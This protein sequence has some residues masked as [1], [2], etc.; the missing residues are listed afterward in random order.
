MA[1]VKQQQKLKQLYEKSMAE[2]G[3][4]L[5]KKRWEQSL[6][7]NYVEKME[8][9]EDGQYGVRFEQE[10]NADSTDRLTSVSEWNIGEAMY[11]ICGPNWRNMLESNKERLGGQ[12]FE[13]FGSDIMPG[14]MSYVTAGLDVVGGL[15]NARALEKNESPEWIYDRVVNVQEAT[16]EGGFHIGARLD[17]SSIDQTGTDL[18]DGQSPPTIKTIG[19]RVHRNRTLR[20]RRRTKLNYWTLKWDLT[21]QAMDAVDETAI[22]VLQERERKCA[23]G[24]LGVSTGTTLG[25]GTSQGIQG[26]ALAMTQDGLNFFPWQNGTYG[27]NANAT[28][29]AQENGVAVANF[30]NCADSNGIGLTNYQCIAQ[31]LQ[32]LHGNRDPFTKLPLRLD[33]NRMQFIC[34]PAVAATQLKTL[35]QQQALWQ[36]AW[37]SATPSSISTATVSDYNLIKE[38][39]LDIIESQFWLN[40]AVDAGLY[41][42]SSTGAATHQTLT[43]NSGDTQNTPGSIMSA[44]WMGHFKRACIY[45]QAQPYQAVQV[46]LDSIAIGEETVLIQDHCERGQLF[47]HQP[48]FGWRA[49]A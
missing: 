29:P 22:L 7:I 11:S 44:F 40:R 31:A 43:N 19:T 21:S 28:T 6:G 1:T 12:R 32:V 49:W 37:G 26:N 10:Y 25:A 2:G 9:T 13:G 16:G 34:A 5:F 23:D 24:V 41:S 45:W 47:W 8:R 33:F 15:L 42:V 30:A 46:P 4:S 17:P 18:A 48:R 27:T 3:R 38:F 14:D 35:L 39:N 36:I 20:Q